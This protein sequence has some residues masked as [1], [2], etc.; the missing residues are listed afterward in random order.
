M[1][2]YISFKIYLICLLNT[3]LLLD[4]MIICNIEFSFIL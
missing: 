2:D 1:E 3:Y 4:M